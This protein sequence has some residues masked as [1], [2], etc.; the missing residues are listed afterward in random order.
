MRVMCDSTLSQEEGN[1]DDR[2]VVL[3]N[4]AVHVPWRY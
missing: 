1:V 3:V 2:K 4:K